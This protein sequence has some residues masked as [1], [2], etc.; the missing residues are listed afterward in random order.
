MKLQCEA[1]TCVVHRWT[2]G[3]LTGGSKSL[4]AVSWPKQLDVQNVITNTIIFLHVNHILTEQI[5]IDRFPK[6]RTIIHQAIKQD[7]ILL[8]LF[9]KFRI[10]FIQK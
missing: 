5:S 4:F 1:S 3:S 6:R 10:L 2:C 9:I 7:W 8:L